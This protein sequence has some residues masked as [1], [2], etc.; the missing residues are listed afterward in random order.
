M[1]L[2]RQLPECAHWVVKFGRIA[3]KQLFGRHHHLVGGFAATA[4]PPHAIG[5]NSQQA[6]LDAVVAQ[7]GHLVLLVIPVTFMGACCRC[8]P[9]ALGTHALT[10]FSTRDRFWA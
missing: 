1:R 9:V 8:E 2:D 6:T 7:Q 10:R 4:T 5:Q 3:L